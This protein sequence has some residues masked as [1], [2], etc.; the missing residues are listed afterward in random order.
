MAR[1]DPT[2]LFVLSGEARTET[3]FYPRGF[4]YGRSP[5]RAVPGLATA[6]PELPERLVPLRPRAGRT[7]APPYRPIAST[8]STT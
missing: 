3:D 5:R 1:D 8:A 6:L 4:R 2:K 7:E